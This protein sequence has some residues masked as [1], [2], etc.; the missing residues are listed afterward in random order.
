[1][2]NIEKKL[3][4]WSK[5]NLHHQHQQPLHDLIYPSQI[6]ALFDFP[7][8]GDV[9]EFL[10]I[11]WEKWSFII[12]YFWVGREIRSR[13]HTRTSL[14]LTFIWHYSRFCPEKTRKEIGENMKLFWFWCGSAIFV[15]IVTRLSFECKLCAIRHL[16]DRFSWPKFSCVENKFSERMQKN[17]KHAGRGS[18]N[19]LGQWNSS[20]WYRLHF[21]QAPL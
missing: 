13:A 11:K 7:L 16:L 10:G 17:W 14:A 1:M 19:L 5:V 18:C 21:T 8:V 9:E 2:R 3:H 15:N 6:F 4:F 12:A 20:R